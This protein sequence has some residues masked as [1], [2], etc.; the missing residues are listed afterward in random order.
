MSWLDSITNSTDMSLNKLWETVKDRGAWSVSVPGAT[1]SQIQ[2]SES[3]AT[4]G[5]LASH[6]I[7]CLT[8]TVRHG[9]SMLF[10]PCILG[11]TN[12][13]IKVMKS[14]L[15]IIKNVCKSKSERQSTSCGGGRGMAYM[16][17]CCCLFTKSYPT[18]LRLHRLQPAS[19]LCPWDFPGKNTK[20]GCHFLPQGI[21]PTQG[22]SL[23]FLHLLHCRRILYH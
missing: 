15:K 21:F 3:T 9:P 11:D 19:L 20:V 2:L 16:F 17:I 1:R 12:S 10:D 14:Q 23:D 7:H 22:S 5:P 18:L 8:Q 4:G 13:E 6:V